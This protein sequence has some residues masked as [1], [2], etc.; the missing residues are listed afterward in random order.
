MIDGRRVL[1]IDN[2]ILSGKTAQE[3]VQTI[4][5][6][7]GTPIAIGALADLSGVEFPIAVH[8]LLNA[9]LDIHPPSECPACK[10]GIP[11]TEVGY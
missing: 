6:H 7:S 5:A 2:L 1:V 11:V 10:A 8:G 4:T 9:Y 3:L